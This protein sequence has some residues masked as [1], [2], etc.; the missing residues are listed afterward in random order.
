MLYMKQRLRKYDIE[1][2]VTF[3]KSRSRSF[4]RAKWHK[5]GFFAHFYVDFATFRHK[6]LS[7]L[8][9]Y[10]YHHK[11]FQLRYFCPPGDFKVNVKVTKSLNF[12]G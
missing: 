2:A 8:N 5:M 1:S 10:A 12:R 6:F 7:L 9:I 11:F 3:A 4:V